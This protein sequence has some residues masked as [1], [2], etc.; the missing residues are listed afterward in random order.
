MSRIT[1]LRI[2]PECPEREGDFTLG[3]LPLLVWEVKKQLVGHVTDFLRGVP[4]FRIPLLIEKGGLRVRVP[5]SG[6]RGRRTQSF[7]RLRPPLD[8]PSV[9]GELLGLSPADRWRIVN[10]V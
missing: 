6:E 8:R 2:R 7:C 9:R 5:R 1:E 3:T 10:V 4:N